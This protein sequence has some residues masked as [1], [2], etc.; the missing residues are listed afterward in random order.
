MPRIRAAVL[1]ALMCMLPSTLSAQQFTIGPFGG[2]YDATNDLYDE[3][4]ETTFLRLGQN[5]GGT[6][7]AR[8]A[9]WPSSRFGIEVEASAVASDVRIRVASL[10]SGSVDSNTTGNLFMGSINLVW[11]FIRPP[12]EP[13][14]VYVSGGVGVVAR[15][16]DWVDFLDEFLNR[17]DLT[18][19]KPTD[20]A[21]VLGL[22]L[23]YSMARH[24]N[25]R[26]DIK[27]YISSFQVEDLPGNSRLQNDL[28]ITV[29]I[30]YFFGGF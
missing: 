8:I 11:A 6:F 1:A 16:G 26:G 29:G 21:G 4:G 23:K 14:V 15:D 17:V 22:G 9:I 20:F 3:L 30:E 19:Q 28:Q 25:I 24:F 12:L 2:L 27:D 13:L 5:I 7:G 18:Y 10:E